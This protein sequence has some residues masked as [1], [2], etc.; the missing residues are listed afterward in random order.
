MSERVLVPGGRDVTGTLDGGDAAHAVVACPPHPQLGGTRSDPRLRAVSDALV[1]RDVACLRFDYGPWDEGRG[2]RR[3][4]L[5]AVAWARDRFDRVG[6][7]GY[8]FGGSVALV[9]AAERDAI[10]AVSALAPAQSL[11]DADVVA[12]LDDVRC[13]V[14]VVYGDRDD[15]VDAVVV[16][17][18]ARELGHAVECLPADHHFVGQRERVGAL[19]ADFLSDTLGDVSDALGDGN[20]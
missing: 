20:R 12:A 14:Q 3:D 7:F 5:N 15:T 8:S 10:V 11:G 19:V 17:E 16:A 2:E 4:A 1:E 6:L 18:H 13:P 9:A